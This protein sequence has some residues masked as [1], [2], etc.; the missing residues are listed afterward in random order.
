MSVVTCQNAIAQ[1]S[2]SLIIERVAIPPYLSGQIKK[3]D[4]LIDRATYHFLLKD[5]DKYDKF[6]SRFA[7]LQQ[8][9]DS[10]FAKLRFQIAQLDQLYQKADLLQNKLLNNQ[11]EL[12]RTE[13]SLQDY[14]V[15]YD[16][17][18]DEVGAQE[19]KIRY[20][21]RYIFRNKQE[22]RWFW[23]TW[24]IFTLVPAGVVILTR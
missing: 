8:Q 17:Y 24:G 2:D 14:K 16:E 15:K 1:D 22:R 19:E 5:L 10:L 12:I 3:S 21:T 20:R 18:L 23:I 9:N 4:I 6:K 7:A 11:I 13:E